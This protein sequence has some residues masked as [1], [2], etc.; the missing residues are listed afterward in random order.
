MAQNKILSIPQWLLVATTSTPEAGYSAIFPKAGST[1]GLTGSWYI[2]DEYGN[3]KRLAYDY[4]IGAG[5]SYSEIGNPSPY[6]YR[7]DVAIGGGLTYT[8]T[9]SG[10]NTI[11]TF[12]A[13]TGNI[14]W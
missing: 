13:G 2:I 1:N 7:L 10:G 3:E 6:G 12:T 5:L 14:S 4:Y 8:K 11:Y 9:T